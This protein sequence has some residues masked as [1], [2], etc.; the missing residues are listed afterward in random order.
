M[1]K[2]PKFSKMMK[3]KTVIIV[4]LITFYFVFKPLLLFLVPGVLL[5]FF[6]KKDLSESL[7]LIIALS[8]SF[9]IVSF[10]LLSFIPLPLTVFFHLIFI[11]SLLP[12][13]TKLRLKFKK[14]KF[15]KYIVTALLIISIIRF[16]PLFLGFFPAGADMSFHTLTTNLIIDAN[17]VP[18]TYDP[19]LNV[20]F[21]GYPTGF[22]ALSAY[23]SLLSNF[24]VYKSTLLISN[25][26]YAFLLMGLFF[27]LRRFVNPFAAITT[28]TLVMFV[29]NNPQFFISWGGNPFVLSLGFLLFASRFIMDIVNFQ[30]KEILVFALIAS[31]SMLTHIT[32]VYGFFYIYLPVFIIKFMKE[33]KFKKQIL[34]NG[35][36]TFLCI[37]LFIIPYFINYQHINVSA[38]EQNWQLQRNTD[39]FFSW[40]GDITN[41][42]FTIPSFLMLVFGSNFILISLMGLYVS[43]NDKKLFRNIMIMI[44]S[45]VLVIINSRYNILPLS[46]ILLSE[47]VATILIIPLS[48]AIG[49]MIQKL[50]ESFNQTKPYHKAGIFIIACLIVIICAKN[51][52]HY[53]NISN[54]FSMVTSEDLDAFDYIIQ[55]TPEDSYFLNN[56]GDAGLWIS[57]LTY[58]PS[59]QIQIPP[60]YMDE[61]ENLYSNKIPNYVYIGSK[62]VYETNLLIENYE[63]RYEKVYTNSNVHIFKLR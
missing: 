40:K 4:F 23:V 15:D 1:I 26:S 24:P 10:W 39:K 8:V 56:Y 53:V 22:H 62:K 12:F 52:I 17:Q 18:K 58:R 31:A 51:Q 9:W 5:L 37:S 14:T 2:K 49:L 55:N 11:L 48:I 50:F 32:P 33:I 38:D 44:L 41:F 63:N 6:Y 27:L 13:L 35:L 47:R 45:I 34:K 46:F 25:F 42:I 57:A 54:Q 43:I 19:I 60:V 16:I 7:A 30:Y 59:K 28:S 29:T 20:N 36:L 3:Q 21:G 61:K